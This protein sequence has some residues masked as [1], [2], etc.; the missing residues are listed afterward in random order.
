MITT[1]QFN[2]EEN[3][4]RNWLIDFIDRLASRVERQFFP[5]CPVVGWARIEPVPVA[6]GQ[7]A[8]EKILGI[9]NLKQISW[10][11]RGVQV[12]KS[13]CRILTPDGLGTGFLVGRGMIMT[14][15]HVIGTRELAVNSVAEFDYQQDALGRLLPT[16]RYRLDPDRFYTKAE[17]DYTIVGLKEESGKR[18]LESWGCLQLNPNADPIPTEH[19]SIVQHP[20]GGL[21]QIVLTA[22]WVVAAKVPYL[23][24]TTDT[25]PGSSGSPVFNDTW[26]VVAIHH[27]AIPVQDTK[28]GHANEGILMSAIK[29]DAG[30]FWP[31]SDL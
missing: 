23:H 4:I 11:E 26:H 31:N 16:F 12:C 21:K 9:N 22:N 20:N 19:V 8:T 25:M 7:V 3:K 18:P 17:L 14:N 24:Y 5:V 27:A 2:V 13:V 30:N 28:Q 15:N 10:I 6:R 29:A 1:E